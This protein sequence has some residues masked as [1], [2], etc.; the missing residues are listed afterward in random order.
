[1]SCLKL[2]G[3]LSTKSCNLATPYDFLITVMQFRDERKTTQIS[4][5]QVFDISQV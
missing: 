2:N 5:Q 4:Y 3:A 1:M